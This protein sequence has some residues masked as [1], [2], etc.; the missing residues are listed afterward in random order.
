MS[1]QAD[2]TKTLVTPPA[3]RT[4]ARERKRQQRQRDRDLLYERSDWQLFLDLS[5]L[6]QKAGCQPR[7]LFKVVLKE[8]VDNAL[9]AG[10]KVTLERESDGAWVVSDDGRGIDPREVPKFFAVNRPLL[11]SKLKRLP[12]RGMLGNGLRVVMGAVAATGGSLAVDTRAH[13]LVL[14][15]DVA[16]GKTIVVSDTA[17]PRQAGTVVRIRLDGADDEDGVLARYSIDIAGHGKE[18]RGPSSPWWYGPR[19]LHRLFAY[20]TPPETTVGAV[21]RDLGF[22]SDDARPARRLSRDD[23]GV[24]L[25][26]LRDAVKPVPPERLGFI[27][28]EAQDWPGY[29]RKAGTTTT[30]SGAVLPF[31][32]EAW[33]ICTRSAQKGVGDMSMSPMPFV[34]ERA[35]IAHASATKGSTAPLCV[36]VVPAFLA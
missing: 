20:V 6:P 25:H 22:P 23:A 24:V 28:P 10:A 30:Q 36:V 31:V 1:H 26:R 3:E 35:H 29:A 16:T 12:L 14:Q 9:D 5:T 33:A 34:S 2:S 7:N 19:D 27:G 18:Y 32:A 11:S 15:V 4:S 13:R 8:L 17:I 21:C